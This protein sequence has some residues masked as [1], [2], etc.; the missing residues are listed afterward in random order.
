MGVLAVGS[1]DPNHYRANMGTMFLT[2]VGD[3]LNVVLPRYME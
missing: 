1:F 3:I 2:Y